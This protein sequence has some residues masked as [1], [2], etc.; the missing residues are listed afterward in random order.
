MTVLFSLVGA[1]LSDDMLTLLAAADFYYCWILRLIYKKNI[2][3]NMR[4]KLKP[5]TINHKHNFAELWWLVLHDVMDLSSCY[6]GHVCLPSLCNIN[7]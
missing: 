5:F 4:V 6:V 2:I 7:N 1:P 3:Q